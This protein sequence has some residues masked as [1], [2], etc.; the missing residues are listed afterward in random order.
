MPI[1]SRDKVQIAKNLQE[2]MEVAGMG[3]RFAT[4]DQWAN[5]ICDNTDVL[6]ETRRIRA[7]KKARDT[8]RK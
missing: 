4:P 1:S 2:F 5:N 3:D 6:V 7:V 8:R